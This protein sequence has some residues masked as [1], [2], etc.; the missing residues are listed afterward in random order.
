MTG[1]GFC[2]GALS[3]DAPPRG[4]HGL[5]VRR[6]SPRAAACPAASRLAARRVRA[7]RTSGATG[8]A[9]AA[10]DEFDQ[11][12]LA[13]LNRCVGRS[14]AQHN[15]A[16]LLESA[17]TG[18]ALH[19]QATLR[20]AMRGH[21][22]CDCVPQP[23]VT[24][25]AGWRASFACLLASLASLVSYRPLASRHTEFSGAPESGRRRA[26]P[27]ATEPDTAALG[28]LQRRAPVCAIYAPR[29]RQGSPRRARLCPTHA[30]R[31][32]AAHSGQ[33]LRWGSPQLEPAPHAADAMEAPL[34]VQSHLSP[35]RREAPPVESRTTHQ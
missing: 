31:D 25:P 21:Q 29:A 28:E 14:A 11:C 1:P 13:S 4:P 8:G 12:H 24:P 33:P 18:E 5:P 15:A 35:V 10:R 6:R 3:R 9:T 20:A 17:L 34:V 16:L 27:D 7:A 23:L 30:T 26:D 22:C 32:W 2:C 19:D